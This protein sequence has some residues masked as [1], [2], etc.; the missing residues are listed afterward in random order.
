[1]LGA[2]RFIQMEAYVILT[3]RRVQLSKCAGCGPLLIL[4]AAPD[5]AATWPVPGYR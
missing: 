3:P 1:M 4:P 2:T 5:W